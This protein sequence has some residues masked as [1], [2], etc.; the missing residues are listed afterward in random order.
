MVIIITNNSRYD[1]FFERFLERIKF[2]VKI[3]LTLDERWSVST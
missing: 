1:I 3:V 2:V